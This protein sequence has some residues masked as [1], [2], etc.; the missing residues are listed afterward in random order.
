MTA[1]C[2][3]HGISERYPC[4]DCKACVRERYDEQKKDGKRKIYQDHWVQNRALAL[5]SDN[6]VET[7]ARK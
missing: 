5:A 3:K 7:L 4:G 6:L 2:R 1:Y